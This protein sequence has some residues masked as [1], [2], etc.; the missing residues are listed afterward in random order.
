MVGRDD[1]IALNRAGWGTEAKDYV[2]AGERAWASE[3]AWGIWQLPESELGLLPDD[4]TGLDA[5]E[6]GCGTGYVSAWLE[7]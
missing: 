4:L 2:A 3:P 7:R 1:H 6:L 5:L